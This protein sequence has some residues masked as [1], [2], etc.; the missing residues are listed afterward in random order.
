LPD[1]ADRSDYVRSSSSATCPAL[2][3]GTGILPDGD[4]SHAADAGTQSPTWYKGKVFAPGWEVSKGNIDFGGS[5]D[6]GAGLD[7][8]CSVDLDGYFA[9]GGIRSSAF[10]AKGGATFTLSSL[11]SGN[12][13]CA[14]TVKHMKLQIDRQ[15]TTYTW[16]T[17]SRNDIQDGDWLTETWKF[18]HQTFNANVR[19][20]GPERKQL[21]RG[22]RTNL[23]HERLS[24][25]YV[26][27][28]VEETT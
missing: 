19:E 13:H 23:D 12:G 22:R 3:G 25:E 8:L 9:V 4:F 1:A 5:T 16:D 24:L 11:M 6:Y 20:E 18:R 26:T 27:G 2:P 21:R 10:H 28:L 7:G 17:S 14:P 15:F